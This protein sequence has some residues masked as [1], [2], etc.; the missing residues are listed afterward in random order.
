[1]CDVEGSAALGESSDP[2]ALEVLLAR[3]LRA[4]AWDR[5]TPRFIV[6][7]FIGDAV[8]AVFGALVVHEDDALRAGGGDARCAAA[9]G[10]GSADRGQHGGDR[11]GRAW[12]SSVPCDTTRLVT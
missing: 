3:Y 11:D 6:E 1:L 4:N 5:R 10:G 7:K 8:V 2:E 9:V 12:L